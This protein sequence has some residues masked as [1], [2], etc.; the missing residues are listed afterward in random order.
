M[1]A[2][3]R[4]RGLWARAVIGLSWDEVQSEVAAGRPVIA[5]VVG[6]VERGAPIEYT[7]RDTGQTTVVARYEHTVIVV[8]YSPGRVTVLDG[9]DTD[10]HSLDVFLQSWAVLGNMAVIYQPAGRRK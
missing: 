4:Q 1:A 6:H 8:G 2:Q 3:L 10:T 7:P 5:W 9:G